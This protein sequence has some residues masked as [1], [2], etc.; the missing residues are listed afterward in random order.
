MFLKAVSYKQVP[1]A[2]F[3]GQV[4]MPQPS[5]WRE[6]EGRAFQCA[7]PVISKRGRGFLGGP[8]TH[9]PA[10]GRRGPRGVRKD[11]VGK[12]SQPSAWQETCLAS[13]PLLLPRVGLWRGGRGALCRCIVLRGRLFGFSGSVA[14]LAATGKVINGP[15]WLRVRG[16]GYPRTI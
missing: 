10:P 6:W 13:G 14:S 2:T 1:S 4:L 15:V 3:I 5:C 12:G 7:G 9:T 16:S 8:V 11:R